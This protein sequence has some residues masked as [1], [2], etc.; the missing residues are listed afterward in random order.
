MNPIYLYLI[1]A[2]EVFMVWAMTLGVMEIFRRH[3]SF[4]FRGMTMVFCVSSVFLLAALVIGSVVS[5]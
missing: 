3:R 4:A 2:T 5:L 1:I